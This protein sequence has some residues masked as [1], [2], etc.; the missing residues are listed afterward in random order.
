MR[1]FAKK[2]FFVVR[3]TGESAWPYLVSGRTYFATSLRSPQ[4]GDFIVFPNPRNEE[5]IFIKRVRR[6][7]LTGCDVESSVSWGSS[8]R[9]FGEI[10]HETVLGTIVW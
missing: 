5:E 4:I 1:H 8:S 9:D 3:V 2:P 10:P 7:T 6:I